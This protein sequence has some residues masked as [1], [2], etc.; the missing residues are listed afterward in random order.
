V[1]AALLMLP[2]VGPVNACGAKAQASATD[3]SAKK[4]PIRKPKEKV[5]YM[6]A[7]PMK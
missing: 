5:E 4:K 3:L 2:A 6:R 7:A 1:I